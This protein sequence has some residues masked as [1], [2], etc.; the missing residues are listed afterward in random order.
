MKNPSFSWSPPPDTLTDL[1]LRNGIDEPLTAE[2][3]DQSFL[4]KL[5][6]GECFLPSFQ[7]AALNFVE[8][9]VLK[10]VVDYPAELSKVTGIWLPKTLLTSHAPNGINPWLN[11]SYVALDNTVLRAIPGHCLHRLAGRSEA[12]F[13]F[14][15]R[16]Y[17][18]SNAATRDWSVMSSLLDKKQHII[19]CLVI[20]FLYGHEIEF[21]DAPLKYEDIASFSGVTK[22]YCIS[23]IKELI[24]QEMIRKKYG[25]LAVEDLDALVSLVDIQHLNYYIQYLKLPN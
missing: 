21:R 4:I 7:E 12:L 15:L 22:Q 9:G 16:R 8:S 10:E 17:E 19:M 20:I 24:G 13:E 11:K 18:I 14:C 6:K 3:L 1:L 23:V 2:I 5:K 25:T